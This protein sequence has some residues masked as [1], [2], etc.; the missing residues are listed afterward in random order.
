MAQ[1]QEIP[2]DSSHATNP[3][4]GESAFGQHPRLPSYP[5]PD[6]EV[7]LHPYLFGATFGMCGTA[8]QSLKPSFLQG[9]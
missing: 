3:R 5:E 7:P 8:C 4:M 2:E 1:K 6:V 9:R